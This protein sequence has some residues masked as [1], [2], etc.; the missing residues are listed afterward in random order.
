MTP[1]VPELPDLYVLRH[2]E[3]EWNRAR[4]MQGKLDSPLTARGR[5]QA[6]AQ[7]RA[8]AAAGVSGTRIAFFTSPQGRALRTAE[9]VAQAIG[10]APRPDPRLREIGVGLF[11][12]RTMEE[13]RLGHPQVFAGREP[14]LWYFAVPEGEARAALQARIDTFLADLRGP[15]IVVTHGMT[16]RLLRARVL[17]MGADAF[18]NLPGGQGAV[19]HLSAGRQRV[20]A[21]GVA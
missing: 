7:G 13:N 8:L 12:G 11:T 20:L 17:G 2:G 10:G 16:S 5:A 15:A 6:E 19:Y 14:F 18:Q 21:E 3:T 1:N 4:R 9:I